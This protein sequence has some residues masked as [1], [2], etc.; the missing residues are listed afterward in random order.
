MEN[1]LKQIESNYP[2]EEILVNGE[3]V[4]PYLRIRYAFAHSAETTAS[5]GEAKD[6][7]LAPTRRKPIRMMQFTKNILRGIPYGF[8]NWFRNYDYI[9]LTNNNIR[10]QVGGKYVNRF[11]DPI[12]D[13]IGPSRVLCIESTSPVPPYEMNQ[14]YTRHVV[15]T[16]LLILFSLLIVLLRRIFSRRYNVANKGV[17][18]RIEVD[19]GLNI[20][21]INMIEFF[22]ASRK[23]FTCLFRR[24]RPKA[25][26]LTCYY[27]KESAIRAAKSLGIKVIEIQ[28]GVIG[29]EHPA[30]NVHRD[31]DR[32]CFPDHL[33][34][35]GKQEL[36]TF[37]NSSFIDQANVHPVGSFYIDYIRAS[38]R[39][40]P[41]LSERIS[42]Y[43]KI[44]GVTLQWDLERRLISFIC[45]A[46]TLDS[47]IL[48]ILIP[49]QEKERAYSTMGLPQNVLVI[50]DKN[51]YELMTY[52]DFQSTVSSTCA[53]EA[54][55]LGV[56]NI[57]VDIDGSA[58]VYY[59]K[60][61]SDD[62]VTRFANTPEEYVDI[63][64]SFTRL[65]KNIV[66]ELHK[67]FFAPNYQENI[68]DFV[69]TYLP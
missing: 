32:S 3:Q 28:H 9:I 4:W 66:C 27:G 68:R 23:V 35:F 39:P 19:F 61:L 31:V 56:Q 48:Y 53:L 51:F 16:S 37:N 14:V 30:Y 25:V 21:A 44:V 11:V 47:S 50:R 42:R 60:V 36:S 41:Y 33:L 43:K 6:D 5:Y 54:P 69:K 17:M 8:R 45:E 34:V 63:V 22:E 40:E 24:M 59:E 46:A 7:S 2:V 55:S 52:C 13:E 38:Y 26:L 18:D 10:R 57:L 58:R 12:I 67:D 64:K 29:K 62:R 1:I 49:R 65:D 20:N 15:S